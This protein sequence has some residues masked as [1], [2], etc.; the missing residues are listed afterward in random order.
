MGTGIVIAA[1]SAFQNRE[2]ILGLARRDV[3]ARYK[4]STL[5]VL[6]VVGEQILQFL[7]Y[8]FVFQLVLRTRWGIE[9]SN[10]SEVPFGLAL[11]SGIVLHLLLADTLV[12]SPSLVVS[13]VSYVKR[14]IFPLEILPL[15]NVAGAMVSAAAGAVL[16]I[17]LTIYFSGAAH[18]SMLLVPVPILLLALLTVGIGWLLS[19]VGVFF[20]DIN[21]FMPTIAT[22]MLF[23][24]PICYPREAVPEAFRWLMQINPLTIPL[25]CLRSLL[26]HGHYDQWSTLGMYGASAAL[27]A[28]LG[29]WVFKR[30]RPGFADVI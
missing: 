7:V 25:E 14:V 1:R 28:M 13:N 23:T 18:L 20:R 2:L 6:W 24:A 12:R 21:Q 8:S 4:N 19:S 10:G 27:I 22:L 29:H 9:L 26:F 30:T 3:A 5:G 16:L 17:G 15:V 11:Y